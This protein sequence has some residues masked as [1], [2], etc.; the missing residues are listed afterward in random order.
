MVTLTAE[1]I[2]KHLDYN[3]TH[4]LCVCVRMWSEESEHS[5]DEDNDKK[6]TLFM[7]MKY[8]GRKGQFFSVIVAVVLGFVCSRIRM[9]SRTF[10]FI[11][12]DKRCS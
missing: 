6:N 4:A 1:K 10:N 7:E 9:P 11:F 5:K 2:A 8:V 12:I 3:R